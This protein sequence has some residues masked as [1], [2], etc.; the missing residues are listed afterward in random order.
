MFYMSVPQLQAS[1]NLNVNGQYW[2][3]SVS[4]W[5]F[6]FCA[7]WLFLKLVVLVL[8]LHTDAAWLE[9]DRPSAL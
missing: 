2:P 8:P 3:L 1:W 5:L 9:I 4:L 7:A 6:S